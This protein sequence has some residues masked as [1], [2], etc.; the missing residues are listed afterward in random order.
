MWSFSVEVDRET[1]MYGSYTPCSESISPCLATLA[2][3]LILL[4][5]QLQNH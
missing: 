4:E 5:W 3:L 1:L 2:R